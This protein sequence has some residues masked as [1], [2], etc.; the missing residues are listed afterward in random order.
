MKIISKKN[1]ILLVLLFFGV[2]NCLLIFNKSE[3]ATASITSSKTV[4]VGESVTVTGTVNAAT[5]TF[6]LTGAGQ[7]KTDTMWLKGGGDN[8]SESI[9]ITFTPSKEGTTTFKLSGT[10]VDQSSGDGRDRIPIK[11]TCVITAKGTSSSSS[12]SSKDDADDESKI[13]SEGSKSETNKSRNNYLSS[14]KVSDGTLSPEF[15]RDITS[16]TINFDDENTIKNLDKIKITATADDKTAK[17]TGTGEKALVEGENTFKINVK[18]ESGSTRTYVIKVTKPATIKESDL[19]LSSLKVQTVDNEGNSADAELDKAFDKETLEYSMNVESNI[20]GLNVTAIPATTDID[21]SV[22]GNE[23]LHD[24]MNEVVITLT[25]KED[26]TVQTTYKITVNK[27]QSSLLINESNQG[28]LENN[29]SRRN[30]MIALIIC[31]VIF[32]VIILLIIW[33]KKG[34]H[35]TISKEKFEKNM[36]HN[37]VDDDDVI[38][39]DF[40]ETEESSIDERKHKKNKKGK[41]EEQ[42]SDLESSIEESKNNEKEDKNN[43][44]QKLEVQKDKDKEEEIAKDNKKNLEDKSEIKKNTKTENK[45]NKKNESKND[46]DKK[47][48]VKTKQKKNGGKHF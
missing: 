8:Y 36:N 43:L 25:S 32:V 48:D 1:K 5:A 44:N 4:N 6:E 45:E 17:V 16:Y 23:N 35:S 41:H 19:R 28:S 39:D 29:N 40:E 12:P 26:Q 27:A 24:G 22:S 46:L 15:N 9:S 31:C 13:T 21:V 38:V 34:K 47:F 7:T 3:A 2:I 18:S 10:M 14:L 33:Y 20:S 42:E 11:E 37:F 30:K